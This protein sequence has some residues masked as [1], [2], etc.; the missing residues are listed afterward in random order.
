MALCWVGATTWL[1]EIPWRTFS[2]VHYATYFAFVALAA[3]FLVRLHL[4][5]RREPRDALMGWVVCGCLAV[6]G[7][8]L[9]GW[10]DIGLRPALYAG[11]LGSAYALGIRIGQREDGPLPAWRRPFLLGGALGLGVLLFA[12]SFREMWK[13]E[14]GWISMSGGLVGPAL[15]IA[16]VVALTAGSCIAGIRLLRKADWDRGLLACTPLLILPGWAAGLDH[17]NA[18]TIMLVVNLYAVGV[19]LTIC[20]RNANRGDLVVAN[21]GLLLTLVVLTARFFDAQI[22]FVVRGVGFIVLGA[23]FLG[24]NVWML[25]RRVEV[26][27]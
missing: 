9:G 17:G 8:P 6:A 11:M 25:R 1:T 2:F 27:S 16:V 19:G 15:A 20:V 7:I 3:P 4:S 10:P 13:T 24:T 23:V 12:C 5:D 22:S 18:F 26:R 14:W 21:A